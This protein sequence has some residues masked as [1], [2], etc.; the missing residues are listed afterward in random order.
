MIYDL[1]YMGRD[2]RMPFSFPMRLVIHFHAER[3]VA[4][5]IDD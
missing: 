3:V 4:A 5:E 1:G 2:P